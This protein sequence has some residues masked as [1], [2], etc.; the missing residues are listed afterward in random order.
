M[1]RRICNLILLA[2][3]LFCA[4]SSKGTGEEFEESTDE[5]EESEEL[6]RSYIDIYREASTDGTLHELETVRSIMEEMG[7]SGYAV[8]DNENQ[9]NMIH[10]EVVREFNEAVERAR[11]AE[12]AVFI[13]TD[14]GG[15]VRYDLTAEGGVV[16][17]DR[18]RLSWEDGEP[19]AEQLDSYEAHTWRLDKESGYLYI[20][21]EQPAG[22]DGSIGYTAIR[23]EPLDENLRELNRKYILSVG[24]RHSNLFLT[25][26]DETD[27]GELDFYDLFEMFY[28]SEYGNEIPYESDFDKQTYEVPAEEFEAV[29]GRALEIDSDTLRSHTVYDTETSSYLYTTRCKEDWGHPCFVTPEVRGYKELDDGT[30]RLQ[31]SSVSQEDNPAHTFSHVVEIRPLSDGRYQYVSNHILSA[32]H[33]IDFDWYSTRLTGQ[34]WEERYGE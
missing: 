21:K 32:D 27:Y 13:V 5:M 18:S 16:Q 17:V 24:Y 31:V 25:D 14:D 28:E 19:R 11:E 7:N 10:P 8:V 2:A 33:E 34:E 26:W 29:I 6:A 4:C 20:E 23:V 9:I 15:F 3:L 30:I 12:T 1:K 22:Y